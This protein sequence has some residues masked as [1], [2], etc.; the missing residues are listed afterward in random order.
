MCGL[1]GLWWSDPGGAWSPR[2]GDLRAWAQV[3]ADALAHRGP[4]DDGIWMQ[5]DAGLVLAHRRLAVQDPGPSGHQPWVTHDGRHAL[6]F[7][8]EIYNQ[9]ELRRALELEGA[10][11]AS[12]CDTEVL[13]QALRRWGPAHTLERLEGM[14]ALA[15]WDGP[16]RRLVLA[17]D[18][19]GQKPLV[20]LQRPQGVAFAS[21][22]AAFERLPW[23]RPR[24]D[25]AALPGYLAFGHLGPQT[26]ML[27]GV[28]QVAPGEWL[29]VEAAAGTGPLRV[30][31]QRHWDLAAE[32]DR[33]TAPGRRIHRLGDARDALRPLVRQS[34]R[35]C[36]RAD[37]PVGAFLSGGVDSSLVTAQLQQAGVGPVRSY[38]LGFDDS[39][40][41]ESRE[42]AAVARHLATVHAV[43][44]LDG[45][46]AAALLPTLALAMD[47]P[48]ADASLLPS[49]ALAGRARRDVK[50][51]L[52]G[53]G[54][55]EVFGGY[56]RYRIDHGWLGALRR[57]PAPWRDGL[58]RSL[59]A[60]PPAWWDGAARL[61]PRAWRPTRVAAK[62]DK[63]QR[64]LRQAAPPPGG[65]APGLAL[66]R[67]PVG[68]AAQ[69]P[70]AAPPVWGPHLAA[71]ERQQAWETWHELPGDLLP[72]MDRATMWWGLEAR[73]PLLDLAL[74][75]LAWRLSPELKASSQGLKRV[76]RALLAEDLPR[77][78]FDRPKQGFSVPLG[79][80][81]R[82]PLKD[83]AE[84][85]WRSALPAVAPW[86]DAAQAEGAWREH[87]QG[88]ADHADRL[89]TLA[90][91]GLWLQRWRPAGV[92][93]E[94]G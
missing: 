85:L 46:G 83:P 64:L 15:W 67:W 69:A 61:V 90:V 78:L 72:K 4:D 37:V 14:Y 5:P 22:V 68:L 87:Q 10:V 29:T 2:A 6:V 7:N 74:V 41:D 76:L 59:H 25:P 32:V 53:D 16:A 45:P 75:R 82:G 92:G 39:L 47:E 71:C 40:H 93:A 11:F 73:S 1:A 49:L 28:R 21:T 81:L 42:A 31:A 91:L 86:V 66:Q 30:L 77:H 62:V 70:D 3:M 9:A 60:V 27:E 94:A 33:A 18:P 36:A 52:T 80:W 12:R 20:W 26:S 13:G 24:L 50:V 8:G 44:R 58:A 34:V 48:L 84:A 51:V 63:L 79:A 17:R 88:R 57:A 43:E 65:G 54:G 35:R 89:W 23:F 56:A 55:D 38:A 19:F